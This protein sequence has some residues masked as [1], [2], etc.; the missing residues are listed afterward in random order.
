[1]TKDEARDVLERC[2]KVL[3]YRDCRSLNKVKWEG[4][5]GRGL[6]GEGGWEGGGGLFPE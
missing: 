4:V 5:D 1:M 3:F 6:F 2:L